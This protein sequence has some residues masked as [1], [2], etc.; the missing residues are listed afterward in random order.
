MLQDHR[1]RAVVQR[2]AE[3]PAVDEVGRSPAETREP[4]A[5]IRRC[6]EFVEDGSDY[7]GVLFLF[8]LVVGL[9]YGR[10]EVWLCQFDVC[11][12]CTVVKS[13]R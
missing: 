8:L 11:Y 7:F 10:L 3:L 5:G 12:I 6:A 9:H 13:P 1:S 4:R 2:L